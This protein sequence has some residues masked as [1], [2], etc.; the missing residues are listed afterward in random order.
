ML[1]AEYLSPIGIIDIHM[2]FINP[3][4]DIEM[5]CETR[6]QTIVMQEPMSQEADK[7]PPCREFALYVFH[8]RNTWSHFSARLYEFDK[9]LK[10]DDIQAWLIFFTK[11][12][13]MFEQFLFGFKT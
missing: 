9:M 3:R 13:E 12:F 2:P 11:R 10:S 8:V 4:N 5:K 7:W 6:F 1:S